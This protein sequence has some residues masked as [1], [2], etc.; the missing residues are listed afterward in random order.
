MIKFLEFFYHWFQI[1]PL[2]K[3]LNL[4]FIIII[5]FTI[6]SIIKIILN[7][8]DIMEIDDS[9][10]LILTLEACLDDITTFK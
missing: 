8:R 3:K 4:F 6:T 7:K 9:I 1:V 5:L 2:V 10:N